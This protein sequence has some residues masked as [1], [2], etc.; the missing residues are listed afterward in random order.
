MAAEY[1]ALSADHL[2]YTTANGVEAMAKA[3]SVAVMLPGAFLTLGETQLPPIDALRKNN[4]PMAVATDCN[5]GTSPI[6][7]LRTA[8]MLAARQFRMTPEECFRGVTV[9]AA[10]ALGID[11]E[12][13]A[14]EA[15]KRADMAFWNVEHPSELAYYLG[16]NPCAAVLHRGADS[17]IEMR[18]FGSHVQ[19][20]QTLQELLC[21]L[22]RVNACK[23]QVI[24]K[25]KE[26]R[27][28]RYR[29]RR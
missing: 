5:P 24:S 9:N 14:L 2:E 8:M 23:P 17:S 25:A 15:G 21:F 29:R 3:G 19:F 10:R 4:V 12:T 11:N 18:S 28:T 13:G 1:G 7:S 16:F 26:R 27:T 20:S 22:G 6:C